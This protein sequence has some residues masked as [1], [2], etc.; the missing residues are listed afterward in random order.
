MPRK[1][2]K[3]KETNSYLLDKEGPAYQQNGA[4]KQA[5]VE[6]KRLTEELRQSEERFRA[7]FEASQDSIYLKDNNVSFAEHIVSG[8]RSNKGRA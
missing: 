7:I 1:K 3:H 8:R 5:R 6:I 4:L 2:K